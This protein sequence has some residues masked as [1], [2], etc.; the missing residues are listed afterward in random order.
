M[1]ALIVV[2]LLLVITIIGTKH[3]TP[4]SVAMF[5][6]FLSLATLFVGMFTVRQGLVVL[7]TAEK[8]NRQDLNFYLQLMGQLQFMAIVLFI[9]SII[10]TMFIIFTSLAF[11][12]VVLFLSGLGALVVFSSIHWE[13][14]ITVQNIQYLAKNLRRLSSAVEYVKYNRKTT[15][16]ASLF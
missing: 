5:F 12:F 10:I 8:R 13:V 2:F 11:P 1:A 6:S 14:S 16:A 7:G 15:T 3:R 9:I 4:F